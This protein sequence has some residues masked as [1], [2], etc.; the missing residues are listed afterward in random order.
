MTIV[1]EHIIQG[2][3]GV[4][5]RLVVLSCREKAVGGGHYVKVAAMT[6]TGGSFLRDEPIGSWA[7]II[8]K[9]VLPRR[10]KEAG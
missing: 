6:G 10:L 1:M 9:E 7:T 4:R 5:G 8:Y 2:V 3:M